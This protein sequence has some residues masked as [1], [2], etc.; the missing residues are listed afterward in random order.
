MFVDLSVIVSNTV[1]SRR[2]DIHAIKFSTYAYHLGHGLFPSTYF[3]SG[4]QSCHR[5]DRWISHKVQ[6]T[7]K[8]CWKLIHSEYDTYDSSITLSCIRY[9]S[10]EI[11]ISWY[12]SGSKCQAYPAR[13]VKMNFYK[14][15]ESYWLL[16]WYSALPSCTWVQSLYCGMQSHR[17]IR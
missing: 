9:C 8:L 13:L 2:M 14:C 12:M 7:K 6:H 5:S 15:T 17:W 11:V 16:K 3:G 4:V 1:S 10:M